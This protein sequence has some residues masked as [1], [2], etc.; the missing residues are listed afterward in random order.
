MTPLTLSAYLEARGPLPCPQASAVG[1]AVGLALARGHGVG[2]VYG[3]I[4]TSCIT[5]SDDDRVVLAPPVTPAPSG[6]TERDDVASAAAVVAELLANPAS[7][8]LPT[9]RA[10]MNRDAEIPMQAGTFAADLDHRVTPVAPRAC[11]EAGAVKR[12][13][14]RARVGV[15]TNQRVWPNPGSARKPTVTPQ[16]TTRQ[17]LQALLGSH[18]GSR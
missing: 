17:R 4:S 2:Q 3:P 16:D 13:G 18:S 8:L 1:E 7:A 15:R 6:W 9:L 10:A 12:S 11:P 5:I 14:A